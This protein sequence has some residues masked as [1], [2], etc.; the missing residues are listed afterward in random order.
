M[1]ENIGFIQRAGFHQ[2]AL[3]H[4][5]HWFFPPAHDYGAVFDLLYKEDQPGKIFRSW[6][7]GSDVH[8][9]WNFDG[10]QLF[11]EYGL[12]MNWQW[13]NYWETG[14]RASYSFPA[15][16]DRESRGLGLYRKPRQFFTAFVI[17]SDNRRSI[18]GLF[19]LGYMDDTKGMRNWSGALGAEIRPTA[20]AEFNFQF[21]YDRTGNREAWVTNL[22]DSTIASNPI[23]IFAFRD[24]EGYD[25]TLRSNLTF[26]RDLTLQ[27]YGQA[28]IT[29]GHYDRFE[30]LVTPTTLVPYPYTGNP[31][32]NTKFFNL[33]VI[34]RWE[35]RPGSVLYLVWTQARQGENDDYFTSVR[36]DFRETFALPADNVV[37][38]KVSYWFH[39]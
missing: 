38:L 1:A 5:R 29:K 13:L 18:I 22:I 31:D 26:T 2:P 24:T 10:A 37:L 32:F 34:W 23:S 36:R 19:E 14:W 3:Q 35:Y 25:L 27:I 11:N 9:R 4:Q 30:R 8:L 16:D 17:E 6:N 33:N 20:W 12:S 21:T 28:F 39:L 15:D 7:V